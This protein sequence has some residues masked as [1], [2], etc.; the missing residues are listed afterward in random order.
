[1]NE[2]KN[3]FISEPALNLEK[4]T[5]SPQ[6]QTYALEK[7]GK[8]Q[9]GKILEI[10]PIENTPF[11][12]LKTQNGTF[13]TVGNKVIS[14][15][16]TEIEA[17]DK[18]DNIEWDTIVQLISIITERVVEAIKIEDQLR[19]TAAKEGAEKNK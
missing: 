4:N 8:L 9:S 10:I 15:P 14:E 6:L 2:N 5:E 19:S 3:G 17:M 16:M 13:I 11:H 18:I 1:M 7:D 12:L